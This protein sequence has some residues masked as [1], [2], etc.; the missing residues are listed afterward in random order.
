[1]KILQ[2]LQETV[3]FSVVE[4]NRIQLAEGCTNLFAVAALTTLVVAGVQREP[5]KEA[6]A[7]VFT[8]IYQ[9]QVLKSEDGAPGS[10]NADSG[11]EITYGEILEMNK[12]AREIARA[13]KEN[14]L[15]RTFVA[16]EE[17]APRRM[18]MR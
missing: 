16:S 9:V 11:R 17:H 12:K 5:V 4:Q 1:M 18:G 7:D 14:E 3:I 13:F 2:K 6:L 15:E 10:R 8:K